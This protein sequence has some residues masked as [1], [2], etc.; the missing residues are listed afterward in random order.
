MYPFD[1][2]MAMAMVGCGT[3]CSPLVL[4]PNPDYK[5]TE[6]WDDTTEIRS[7][8]ECDVAFGTGAGGAAGRDD[9]PAGQAVCLGPL[10]AVDGAGGRRPG[11][12]PPHRAGLPV[13]GCGPGAQRPRHP[14]RPPRPQ[15]AAGTVHLG[16]A[17]FADPY[18]A[19][20]ACLL[21]PCRDGA[22]LGKEVDDFLYLCR[23]LSAAKA[24]A[25]DIHCWGKSAAP[26]ATL[27][28]TVCS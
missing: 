16:V 9:Q 28:Q 26:L 14:G 6:H 2:S 23:V 20:T 15:R 7:Y 27:A 12:L 17:H 10:G 8:K 24:A 25:C 1:M 13:G 11:A 19:R 21:T 3:V 4:N 5:A 22:Y 18:A